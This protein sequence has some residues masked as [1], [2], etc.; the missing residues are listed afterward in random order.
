MAYVVEEKTG[1]VTDECNG[2]DYLA[3]D[4]MISDAQTCGYGVAFYEVT[5]N[6]DIVIWVD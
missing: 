5:E 4:R 6:G 3:I 2:L 1:I